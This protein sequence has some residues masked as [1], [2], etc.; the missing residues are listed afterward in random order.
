MVVRG[1][2]KCSQHFKVFWILSDNLDRQTGSDKPRLTMGL[3]FVNHLF[4]KSNQPI[5]SAAISETIHAAVRLVAWSPDM[6]C[7]LS[8]IRLW[9][10]SGLLSC[11]QPVTKRYLYTTAWSLSAAPIVSVVPLH[12]IIM[13]RK[14]PYKAQVWNR[15]CC[16]IRSGGLN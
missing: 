7:L 16:W 9:K 13:H 5:S 10:I 11:L 15:P 3:Y 12:V 4:P 14:S 6:L 8:M 1:R 2:E